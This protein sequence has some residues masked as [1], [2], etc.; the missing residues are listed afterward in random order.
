MTETIYIIGAGAIGKALAVFLAARN[1]RVMLIRGSVD[2]CADQIVPLTVNL[3]GGTSVRASVH[4]STFSHQHVLDGIIVLTNKSFANPTIARELHGKVDGSPIV[5]MQN[6]LHVEQSFLQSNFRNVYRCVLFA[7]SQ[8]STESALTFKPVAPS[9]I[10]IINGDPS[11][12]PNVVSALSTPNFEF[13]V[14]RDIKPIVWKKVIAN[15]VFNS[16]CPLL[17]TDNGIFH[18]DETARM[19]AIEIITECCGVAR[20]SG[21]GLDEHA[22]LEMVL[23]ISRASDGQIIS[24]LQDIRNKRQTE[25]DSLNFAI[26]QT[27]MEA[28]KLESVQKTR[29]LGDLTKLKSLLNR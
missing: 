12:L 21:V 26:V 13:V 24:T 25:I 7:T 22:V 3:N 9:P 14:E 29:L 23:Q 28:G 5:L 6:G 27:A 10:G 19:L 1:K 17:E 16:I 18:R 2:H 20:M 15:C 11:L 4:V 8:P